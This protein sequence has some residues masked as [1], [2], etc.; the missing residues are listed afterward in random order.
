MEISVDRRLALPIRQQIKG[1]I[2]YGIACGE[3]EPGAALPSVRDLARKAGVAPMTVSQ[4]YAELKAQGLIETW[5][6]SR[7]VVA[8]SSHARM[9]SRS[10]AL[11][12]RT[13]IDQLIDE[14]GGMGVG[15]KEL[16]AMIHA[17]LFHRGGGGRVGVVMIALFPEATARYAAA[18]AARLGAEACVDWLIIDELRRDPEA[19]LRAEAADLVVTLVNRQAEVSGLLPEAKVLSIRFTPSEET[20]RALASVEPLARVAAVSK[21]ADFFP[22]LQAGVRRFAPH[23]L[24][25][26][27]GNIDDPDLDGMLAAADLVVYASGADAVLGRLRRSVAAVEYTHVPDAADIETVIRPHVRAIA[28]ERRAAGAEAA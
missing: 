27:G 14:A 7:T 12:L 15:P 26:N 11:A 8:D 23:V 9:M 16:S 25:V 6:G 22:I 2:E 4:V 21:I 13:R 24:E 3:F 18:I 28:R 1:L 19:R 5:P 17:R 10:G 20:R